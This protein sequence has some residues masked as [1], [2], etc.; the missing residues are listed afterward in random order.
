M[1]YVILKF[2]EEKYID[3]T[4]DGNLRFTRNEYFIDLENQNKNKGIGD[5][6]EG[7]WSSPFNT[8][9]GDTEIYMAVEGGNPFRLNNARGVNRFRYSAIKDMPVCCFTILTLQ[10]DFNFDEKKNRYSIKSEVLNSLIEQ[11]KGRRLVIFDMGK[12]LDKV[13]VACKMK[14]FS[15]FANKV[16]YYDSKIEEHPMLEDE[17]HQEPWRA[18]LY[19]DAYFSS[20]KE[21]RIIINMPH[22]ESFNFQLGKLRDIA[23]DYGVVRDDTLFP[24]IEVIEK[25]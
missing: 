24:G 8:E 13:E 19:K 4:L 10:E 14:E 16:N 17:F 23:K 12:L 18:L 2:I 5:K 20:Q 7:S 11:F 25:E 15:F 9:S 6:Y 1:G 3:S 21:Y 22:D